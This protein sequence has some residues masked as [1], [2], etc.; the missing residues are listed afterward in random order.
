[1]QALAENGFLTFWVVSDCFQKLSWLIFE[2]LKC[3]LSLEPN[4]LRFRMWGLRS[5]GFRVSGLRS[6]GFRVQGL[7]LR[8]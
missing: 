7:G 8:V 4:W 1:M 6:L 5:L 3:W 2:N